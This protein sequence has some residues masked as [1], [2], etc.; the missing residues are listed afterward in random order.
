MTKLPAQITTV[1]RAAQPEDEELRR[2]Q[3]EM[4]ALQAELVQRELDLVTLEREIETF[5]KVYV[6][7]LGPALAE[8]ARLDAEIQEALTKRRPNDEPLHERAR[9][10]RRKADEAQR[11]L[12]DE[13]GEPPASKP[14]N[15]RLKALFR[16]AAKAMHPDL[17]TDDDDRRLRTQ[18]MA[19]VNAAFAAGDEAEIERLLREWE[20]RPESVKGEGV[21]AELVRVI[22]KIA[23]IHKRLEEIKR[24][25]DDLSKGEW[26][27][28]RLLADVCERSGRDFYGEMGLSIRKRI[29]NARAR[30]E[31]IT[32]AI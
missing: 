18:R 4:E 5:H 13:R 23:Q 16:Q 24:Q 14:P 20:S 29:E 26:N 9:E 32:T 30:L 11:A 15:E 3:S 28:L 25:M 19:E 17:A 1:G 21:A 8:L 31:E 6:H 7:R 27:E 10:A 2:K 12:E 22:R